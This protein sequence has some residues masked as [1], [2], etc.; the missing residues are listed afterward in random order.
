MIP[1]GILRGRLYSLDRP[2]YLNFGGI[3][4]IL[5][6]EIMHGFGEYGS[7]F[8]F[9]GNYFRWWQTN[10]P[11]KFQEKI[12]CLIDQYGNFTV[13]SL[14]ISVRSVFNFFFSSLLI[15]QLLFYQLNALN[16]QEEDQADNGGF[17]LAYNSYKKWTENRE[18]EPVM[19]FFESRFSRIQLFW[20][21]AAQSWCSTVRDS[22]LKDAIETDK[23]SPKRYRILGSFANIKDFAD[24]F[25]CP[26]GSPMNPTKK[27]DLW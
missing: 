9:K 17:K 10:T 5:G 12:K 25:K 15:F 24:D 22:Y 11:T 19:P 4:Q 8:L 6:H 26:A 23:H 21:S 20:I 7:N 14:N 1:A 18:P 13:P 3:G 16:T 2:R 27:C